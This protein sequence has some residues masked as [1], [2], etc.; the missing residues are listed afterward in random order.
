MT[1]PVARPDLLGALAPR[2]A[3]E[4][5]VGAVAV[6]SLISM[7][8]KGVKSGA[9]F[10]KTEKGQ[11]LLGKMREGVKNAESRYK[12]YES[13]YEREKNPRSKARWKRRMDRAKGQWEDLRLRDQLA[14]SGVVSEGSV[15]EVKRNL[16]S[17]EWDAASDERKK[18]I[19]TQ[20]AKLDKQLHAMKREQDMAASYQG[21][22][23]ARRQPVMP[24]SVGS[25]YKQRRTRSMKGLVSGLGGVDFNVQSPPGPAREVRI[26]LYPENNANEWNSVPGNGIDQAGDNPIVNLQLG[27]IVVISG[28]IPM[29]TRPLEYGTYRVI[30][31]QTDSTFSGT[32]NEGIII[33]G[34]GITVRNMRLYN[35]QKLFLTAEDEELD[36]LTFSILPV[37]PWTSHAPLPGGSYPIEFP[38]SYARRKNRQFASFRDYPIVSEQAVVRVDVSAF[39]AA[40]AGFAFP[41]DIP[42]TCNLVAEI[43]TDKVYGDLVN[44]SPAARSGALVKVGARELSQSSSGRDQLQIVSSYRRPT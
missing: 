5:R 8:A 10:L 9:G 11:R 35:G 29:V 3:Q 40:A 1:K 39:A 20:V 23:Q 26:P 44:P 19:E 7:L 6:L 27:P 36:A 16:L 43:L 21:E 37:R 2:S 13:K 30:G 41:F 12:L 38:L 34:V 25:Y 18:A 15:L 22:S 31:F 17:E 4:D 24:G 28:F 32:S 42:F 14:Q 33:S